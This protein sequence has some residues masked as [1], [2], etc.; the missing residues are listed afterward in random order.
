MKILDVGSI[1]NIIKG[2]MF[3]LILLKN[4][5]KKFARAWVSHGFMLSRT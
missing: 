3:K 1:I 2:D 4:P 5:K